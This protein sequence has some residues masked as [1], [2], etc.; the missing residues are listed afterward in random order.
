MA[1]AEEKVPDRRQS[2]ERRKELREENERLLRAVEELSVLNELSRQIGASSDSQSMMQAIVATSQK[3][4][5]AEQGHMSLIADEEGLS[6]K[7]L[8]RAHGPSAETARFHV[9]AILLGW[10]SIHKQPLLLNEPRSDPRFKGV[11]WDKSLISV[12]C[13]PLMVKS[14]LR[15]ILAVYNKLDGKLFTPG[16]ERLLGIIAGQSAQIV[17]NTRLA[18]AEKELQ[19]GKERALEA[20]RAKSTFLAN[21]SHELRTPL[22]AIIGYTQLLKDEAEDRSLDGFVADLTKIE[23][24]A[25][26]QLELINNI[27]DLSK[28]EAGKTELYLETFAVAPILKEVAAI[29][30][31]L[32][33]RKG[34]TL[35]VDCPESIGSMH[36][37][38]TKIRQ[39]LFNLISNAAKFTENG[40]IRL[41]A[42]TET[43]DDWDWI[44]F[45]VADSGIG[46]A[47]DVLKKLFQPFT[48][49]DASTSKNF[50]GTGLGLVLTKR[51][52][53]MMGGYVKLESELGKG[54]TFSLHLPVKVRSANRSATGNV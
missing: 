13:V 44:R 50:G 1:A 8:A 51:F 39:S 46:M 15:G 14:E 25:K 32:V 24:A 35:V 20:D 29:V 30:Q 12:I 16:D 38:L 4:T 17:E 28:V 2:V 18:E 53:E 33:A 9:T 52:C 45:E 41:R 42:A 6:A 26:H 19:Q 34:N 7:T 11:H 54:T 49:A 5:R 40:S 21:M 3:A 47:P 37:D 10:M 31:P 48:Q 22:N 43:Y 23:A 36:A 27:L